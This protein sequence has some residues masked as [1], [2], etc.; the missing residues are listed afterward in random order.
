MQQSTVEQS[1]ALNILSTHSRTW[2]FPKTK[3]LQKK[4]QSKKCNLNSDFLS[5]ATELFICIDRERFSHLN[6]MHF[7]ITHTLTQQ[8]TAIEL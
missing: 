6:G 7:T 1:A 4:K 2:Y 5:K 8:P 3:Q